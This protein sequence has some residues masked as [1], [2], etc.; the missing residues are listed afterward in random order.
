ML[1]RPIQ[2]PSAAAV[3]KIDFRAWCAPAL[4]VV[5]ALVCGGVAT[6]QQQPTAQML[7][8]KA[9]SDDDN[10]EEVNNAIG[11]FMTSDIDGC[12]AILERVR[13]NNPKLPPSGVMMA[14]LWMNVNR[15]T[16]AR[17][18]LEDTTNKFPADP[19][20]YLILGDLAFQDRRITE[21]S[22]LFNKATDLT[23]AFMENPK[24]KRDFEIRSN[25]GL[26]AVAEARR[27]WETARKHIDAWMALDPDNASARQRLGIA[28]FQL[29]ETD[30]ALEQF[31]ESKKLDPKSL[32][33]ELW[34]ARLYSDAKKRDVARKQI[35]AAVKAA[36]E[37]I[38]VLLGAADWFLG[39]N[40]LEAA[41]TNAD[42]A[43]ALDEKNLN[44]KLVRGT[45]ARIARDYR[46]AERYF[47]DAHTQSPGN[48]AAANSLALVLVE[49][50]DRDARQ[51]AVELAEGNVK[52]TRDNAAIGPAALTTLAWVYYRVGRREEAERIFTQVMQSNQLP[53][54]GGYY[55]ARVL[56]DKG[57]KDK[58]R[59][60]LEQILAGE[61][62][63]ATRAEAVDLLDKI[64]VA[65]K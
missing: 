2:L 59:Q 28:L 53:T 34:M 50:E 11:R 4:A 30:K 54:D 9:V 43:L 63:F 40:D 45:V 24:R 1:R 51:R 10:S 42:A 32:Q 44:A 49:S 13:S 14:M 6:A 57:D 31:R 48:F 46:G 36:P 62:F 23:K 41:K 15:L 19:E 60:I 55:L 33:P 65:P 16:E 29:G 8:G 58:A 17:G 18:E 3:R 21:S 26:A 27:Q 12:K 20:P 56:A 47:N 61:P 22:L 38:T 7:I 37:D 35:E 39:Q 5:A 25:A 52:M 64:K